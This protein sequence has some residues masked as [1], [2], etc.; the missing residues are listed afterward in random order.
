MG[1]LL[2]FHCMPFALVVQLSKYY[3]YN[4]LLPLD[5]AL[6]QLRYCW[7]I[8]DFL[9]CSFPRGT[10][11]IRVQPMMPC[12]SPLGPEKILPRSSFRLATASRPSRVIIASTEANPRGVM[13]KMRQTVVNDPP[14]RTNVGGIQTKSETV[15]TIAF[16]ISRCI[17][18]VY[19]G[20]ARARVRTA[21]KGLTTEIRHPHRL[22]MTATDMYQRRIVRALSSSTMEPAASIMDKAMG[23]AIGIGE[24]TPTETAMC[25]H[26]DEVAI[27]LGIKAAQGERISK[28]THHMTHLVSAQLPSPYRSQSLTRP[29]AV[30]G[31]LWTSSYQPALGRALQQLQK[32]LETYLSPSLEQFTLTVAETWRLCG[33]WYYLPYLQ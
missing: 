21:R 29:K 5:D 23:A 4:F 11:N 20:E 15:A 31:V 16:R 8:I 32:F 14:H 10:T 27:P 22:L 9:V 25:L 7:Q 28:V 2:A 13:A 6:L 33:R 12:A 3:E 19:A 18:R 24:E 26:T 1:A 17:G 30:R